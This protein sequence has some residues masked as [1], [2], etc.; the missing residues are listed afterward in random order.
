MT[1][2]NKVAA[3]LPYL[4]Q[5]TQRKQTSTEV[6]TTYKRLHKWYSCLIIL[7]DLKLLDMCMHLH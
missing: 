3:K 7:K 5:L 1:R 2:L 6:H 4:S